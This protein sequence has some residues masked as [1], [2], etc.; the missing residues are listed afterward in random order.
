MI[1]HKRNDR[2]KKG[3]TLVEL[4]VVIVIVSLLAGIVGPKL[5]GQV[6][7]GSRPLGVLLFGLG[8]MPHSEV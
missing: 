3:F 1:R 7:E 8:V 4:L 6:D 5:F 2:I